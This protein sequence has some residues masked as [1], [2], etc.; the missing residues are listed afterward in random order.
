[1]KGFM[2]S[3]YNNNNN[4]KTNK[5]TSWSLSPAKKTVFPTPAIKRTQS[6]HQIPSFNAF[7]MIIL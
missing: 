2:S 5:V 6:E 7:L 4:Q 1:M 3:L